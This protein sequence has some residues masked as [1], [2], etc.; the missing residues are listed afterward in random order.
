MVNRDCVALRLAMG[1]GRAFALSPKRYENSAFDRAR[2]EPYDG[3]EGWLVFLS[4]VCGLRCQNGASPTR[5]V[6]AC[7]WVKFYVASAWAARNSL[8]LSS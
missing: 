5:R 1:A 7:G 6:P 2:N 3:D 8:L 4:A